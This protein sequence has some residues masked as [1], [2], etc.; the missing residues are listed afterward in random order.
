M[1]V[2]G[3]RFRGDA[4]PREP[5]TTT[6]DRWSESTWCCMGL[7]YRRISMDCQCCRKRWQGCWRRKPQWRAGDPS[8]D[9]WQSTSVVHGK[10][11]GLDWWMHRVW[12]VQQL[13]WIRCTWRTS[14]RRAVRMDG[15]RWR[16]SVGNRKNLVN[17]WGTL[18]NNSLSVVDWISRKVM[19]QRL[20]APKDGII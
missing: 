5:T 16:R 3:K 1:A 11:V 12:S 10:L 2:L 18:E 15:M 9:R 17:F 4:R 6:S 7:R 19:H 14:R 8:R 20:S 13:E